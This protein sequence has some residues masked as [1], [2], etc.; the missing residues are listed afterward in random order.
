M[1]SKALLFLSLVSVAFASVYVTA[2]TAGTTYSGGQDGAVV[3]W[4]SGNDSNPTLEKFG[5]SKI[6]IYVGN[7]KSQ[8][9]LQQLNGNIDVSKATSI[10]FKP[11]ASIGPNSSEYFIRFESLTGRDPTDPTNTPYLSFSAKFTL[12][13]MSGSFNASVQAQIAGQSTAPLASQST[14]GTSG[15]ATSTPSLTSTSA[16]K[17]PSSTSTTSAS[18]KPSSGAMGLKAGWAGI[19]FGAVVGVTMF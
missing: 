5:P 18:S 17:N 8:T 13:N 15:T 19:L 12:N 16:S 2:P 9:P 14:S 4:I 3:S 1:F 7:A 11:D 10:T 6:S